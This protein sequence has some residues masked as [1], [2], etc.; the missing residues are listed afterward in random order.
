MAIG[1]QQPSKAGIRPISF[2][3]TLGGDSHLIW[4]GCK[5]VP[6]GVIEWIVPV[7]NYADQTATA[8]SDPIAAEQSIVRDRTK[9]LHG[10]QCEEGVSLEIVEVG[11]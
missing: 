2:I 8:F 11:E 10:D 7:V 6:I 5:I 1:H 9:R 3:A 4:L